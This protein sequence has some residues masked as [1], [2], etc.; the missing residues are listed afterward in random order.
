[1]ETGTQDFTKDIIA[2]DPDK[3]PKEA[4]GPK[5]KAGKTAAEIAAELRK[6]LFQDEQATIQYQSDI[7]DL[8]ADKQ[9]EKYEALKKKH[10]AY[11]K[12]SVEDARTLNLQL[13]R[14]GE[15]SVQS[16]YDFS[17]TTIEQEV[18][19]MED[20]GKT[21]REI[22]NQR[23]YLWQQLR[24]RYGKDSEYYA[25]ADEQARAARKDV[26]S[27]TEREARDTYDERAKLIERE[28][29]RLEDSGA[30]EAQVAAFKVE[31]WTKLRGQYAKDS[32]YYE[33]ADEAL[34]QARKSLVDKTSK[35]AEAL[36]KAEKVP[37]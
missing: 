32:E 18:R 17:N 19:R 31:Q 4:K 27:A 34:Y 2:P 5:E 25:K 35:L 21:E 30:T 7:Y 29:R 13:K 10:A 14:L 28:V 36:V 24:N 15:D 26:A 12:E 16:R 1:M 8:T 22:A 6:K 33:K 37:Y 9:I 3:P 23:L 11:L 20:A